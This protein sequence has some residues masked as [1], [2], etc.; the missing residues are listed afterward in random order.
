MVIWIF[1]IFTYFAVT[2]VSVCG[3]IM[4]AILHI[5][6][7]TAICVHVG[8]YAHAYRDM[9]LMLEILLDPSSTL[10]IDVC[11]FKQT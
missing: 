9:K 7:H 1:F 3:I 8:M 4:Y 5:Y 10:V 6:G 2:F 11:S